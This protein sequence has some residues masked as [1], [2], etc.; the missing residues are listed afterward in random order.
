M[1]SNQYVTILA[2]LLF[3]TKSLIC[4]WPHSALCRTYTRLQSGHVSD[5]LL[6]LGR[7][8]MSTCLK[9]QEGQPMPLWSH[10]R[11]NFVIKLAMKSLKPSSPTPFAVIQTNANYCEK[12]YEGRTGQGLLKQ[13]L[14]C[15]RFRS[16]FLLRVHG[17]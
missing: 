16:R 10:R 1:I 6:K 3:Y 4:L 2:F 9:A 17:G 8:R 15:E 14:I 13:L 11:H 5:R 7:R 12:H